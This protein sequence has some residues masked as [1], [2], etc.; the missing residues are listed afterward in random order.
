MDIRVQ[1]Q[2]LT[3]QTVGKVTMII[4]GGGLTV[5]VFMSYVSYTV[6]GINLFLALGGAYLMWHKVFDKRR[7]RREED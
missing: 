3:Q 1:A 2:E 6:I 4:G 5:Q 7:D